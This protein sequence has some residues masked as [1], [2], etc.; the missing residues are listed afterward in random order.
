MAPDDT[1]LM[2]NL[3]MVQRKLSKKIMQ[4]NSKHSLKAIEGAVNDLEV[5]MKTFKWLHELSDSEK[6]RFDFKCDFKYEF[7][8]CQ[9][10]LNQTSYY[11]TRAK[12]RD[13]EERE[14]KRKQEVEFEE[15][16]Q[17]QLA[18]QKVREQEEELAKIAL[19]EKRAEYVK[20]TQN[21]MTV[22]DI[23]EKSEKSKSSSK[24]VGFE[25]LLR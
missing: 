25:K 23:E 15:I 12:R 18:E 1:T 24:K 5:A 13:E 14:L 19:I 6:Q 22:N 4:E 17:R 2:Y 3:A 7:K 21:Y 9:D 20:R 8:N 10:L 11:L 16:R